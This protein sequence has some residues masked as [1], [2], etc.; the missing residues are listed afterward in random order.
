MISCSKGEIEMTTFGE[1]VRRLRKDKNLTQRELADL[2][3]VNP[4]YISKIE[5]N[6]IEVLPSEEVISNLATH[7]N[8][9]QELLLELAG[10]IDA[11]MLQEKAIENPDVAFLL[12][13]IQKGLSDDVIHK[14][15]EDLREDS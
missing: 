14:L 11:R 6:T 7:L 15:A 1:E 5:N 8:T 13:R 10:K 4:T 3:K 2:L 12:R 9:S